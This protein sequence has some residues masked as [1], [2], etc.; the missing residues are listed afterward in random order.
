MAL[1]AP[2]RLAGVTKARQEAGGSSRTIVLEK[3]RSDRK[4]RFYQGSGFFTLFLLDSH[5]AGDIPNSPIAQADSGNDRKQGMTA[6]M[7]NCDRRGSFSQQRSNADDND[8]CRESEHELHEHFH[9]C[10]CTF[11]LCRTSKIPY[12]VYL[13]RGI[14]IVDDAHLRIKHTSCNIDHEQYI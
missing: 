6:G 13:L 7:P 4:S 5:F 12:T 8:D 14:V 9:V 3:R 2:M 10:T 1:L 11:V